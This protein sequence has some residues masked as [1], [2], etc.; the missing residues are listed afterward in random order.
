[1]GTSMP[2]YADTEMKAAV[3]QAVRREPP[4]VPLGGPQQ[5]FGI[6]GG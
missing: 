2:P 4:R 5:Q 1:M 3:K 6:C